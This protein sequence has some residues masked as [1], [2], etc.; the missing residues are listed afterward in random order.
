MLTLG[1]PLCDPNP[2]LNGGVCNEISDTDFDCDCNGTL[3]EGRTC[4]QGLIEIT[5]PSLVALRKAFNLTIRAN[6]TEDISL[7]HNF[8]TEGFRAE[9]GDLILSSEDTTRQVQL[10]PFVPGSH[11]LRF[12]LKKDPSTYLTPKPFEV[13][14]R[15]NE[16]SQ[17]YQHF[18]DEIT[19]RSSCCQ[20]E[21]SVIPCGAGFVKLVSSCEWE[22]TKTSGIVFSQFNGLE[23]PT[24][25]SGLHINMDSQPPTFTTSVNQQCTFYNLDCGNVTLF[26]LDDLDDSRSDSIC[27]EYK[28][29]LADLEAFVSRQSL[30]TTFLYRIRNQLPLWMKVATIHGQSSLNYAG[31]NFIVSIVAS[32][33]L[34]LE[35]GCESIIS[36]TSG[37]FAVLHYAGPLQVA[38]E[39]RVNTFDT[40]NITSPRVGSSYCV[41]INLCSGS[42]SPVY[43]GI[44]LSVQSSLKKISVISE[45]I[46]RGWDITFHSATVTKGTL[47]CPIEKSITFWNGIVSDSLPPLPQPDLLLYI[48]S[49]GF[50]EHS[51]VKVQIEFSG[52]VYYDYTTIDDE[53]NITW[54]V[55]IICCH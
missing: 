46:D 50:F 22:T 24:S 20:S 49:N 17:Y 9:Q 47:E 35:A 40:V 12:K 36:D 33:K 30:A 39:E 7:G 5:G 10:T 8:I 19:V 3:H 23:I 1:I 21:M 43:F 52:Q 4:K 53:V 51:N 31:F 48:E 45:F 11:S 2:C 54:Y 38:L 34:S 41:A 27:Y 16:V 32:D 44:P 42:N 28:P 55:L 26:S 25:V 13:F 37:H 14:V 15:K 6:P 29:V 18:S